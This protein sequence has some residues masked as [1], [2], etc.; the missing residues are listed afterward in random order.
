MRM[1]TLATLAAVLTAPTPFGATASD[2]RNLKMAQAV[3]FQVGRDR[4]YRE[5]RRRD[6][7]DPDV[8]VG[9]GPGGVTIGPRRNCRTVTTTVERDDG[10]RIT[11][12]ER[13]CD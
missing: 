7:D 13:L 10:R 8:T 11:R 1:M 4:D 9:V 3:E 2:A 5:R 12:R 6:R